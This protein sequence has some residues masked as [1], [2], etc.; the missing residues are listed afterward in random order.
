MHSLVNIGYNSGGQKTVE[1]INLDDFFGKNIPQVSV[2][3]MDIE[4]GEY[5]ALE[6]MKKLIKKSKNLKL[7]TEFSPYSIK[8]S[9]KSPGKFLDNLKNLGFGLFA[10]D[11][12]EK[13]LSPVNI[14]KFI[15]S[16]PMDRDWHI[17]LLAVK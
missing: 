15:S 17:N 10:I 12:T 11:E 1:T 4:G 14:Q 6:G 2:I 16:C 8:R 13:K 7:F 3:K 5:L 9:K